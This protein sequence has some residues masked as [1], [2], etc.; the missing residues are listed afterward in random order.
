MNL[1]NNISG[2]LLN[3]LKVINVPGG[4]VYR[5]LR[6]DDNGFCG[7]KENNFSEIILDPFKNYKRITV[8]P[9]VWFAF[10]GLS[11]STSI[12]QNVSNIVHDTS[13]VDR[14]ELDEIKFNW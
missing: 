2:L 8:P 4:N 12:L 11:N 9:G 10:Q 14:K 3:D 7:F 6:H 1:D 5:A 13:E